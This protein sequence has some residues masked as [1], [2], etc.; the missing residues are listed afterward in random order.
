MFITNGIDAILV[1]N[2]RNESS[3]YDDQDKIQEEVVVCPYNVD[4]DVKFGMYTVPEATGYYILKNTVD[5]K[6]GDQL[7]FNNRTY[8]ILRVK[9][10]WI[11]N[12]I[13]NFTVAVK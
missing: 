6:E 7:I 3:Y 1:K 9:D 5:V 8:S 11:W 2:N 13:V 4:Q 10:N 12:K